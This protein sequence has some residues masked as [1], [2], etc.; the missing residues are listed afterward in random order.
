MGTKTQFID[1]IIEKFQGSDG[2]P[3]SR[4]KLDGLRKADL[5]EFIKSKGL[6]DEFLSWIAS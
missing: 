5:E 4:S 3:V 6:E 1:F 2:S